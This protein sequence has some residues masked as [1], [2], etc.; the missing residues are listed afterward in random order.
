MCG[1]DCGEGGGVG[2]TRKGSREAAFYCLKSSRFAINKIF[3]E[4]KLH[5][6]Y[7]VI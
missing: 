1:G 4:K 7:F 3:C 6:K 2:V 5:K